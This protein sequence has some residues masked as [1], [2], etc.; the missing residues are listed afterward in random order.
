MITW[1]DFQKVEMHVGTILKV[2]PFPEARNPAYQ[3]TIDF[4]P[5]GIKQSSAQITHLY[6]AEQLT[7]KQVIAVTNF[8][9]KQIANFSSEV[10]VMGGVVDKQ[11][12]I[13]LQPERTIPN[14]TRI[15]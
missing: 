4:G 13:L 7:G 10:L 12:I 6:T 14:G 8:P 3:L 5:L 2:Q 1:E 9:K 15:G 11:N